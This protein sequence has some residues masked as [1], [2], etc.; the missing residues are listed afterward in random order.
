MTWT[1]VLDTLE[2]QLH[3]QETAFRGSGTMPDGLRL[4][5][6]AVPMTDFEQIR[7]IDLMQRHDELITQTLAVMKRTRRPSSTPYSD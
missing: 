7:A 5:H 2:R 6:P 1:N 4:E 3:R